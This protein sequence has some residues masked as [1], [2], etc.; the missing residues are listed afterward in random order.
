MRFYLDE[1]M[2]ERLGG[3]LRGIGHDV[4]SAI[5]LGHR[6]ATDAQQLLIATE[7]DRIL[8]SYNAKD[9]RLL[10]EAWLQWWSAWGVSEQP[11]HPGIIVVHNGKDAGP[12]AI[13]TAIQQLI[14]RERGLANRLFAWNPR[15]GWNEIRL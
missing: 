13:A 14:E 11:R 7:L 5:R 3:S 1:N 15:F 4:T 12:R 2:T 8:I 6:R 10:Q 9:F